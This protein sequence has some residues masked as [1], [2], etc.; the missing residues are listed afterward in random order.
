MHNSNWWVDPRGGGCRNLRT[1]I[2]KMGVIHNVARD[3]SSASLRKS[4]CCYCRLVTYL[5]RKT[6]RDVRI[7]FL[8]DFSGPRVTDTT[9]VAALAMFLLLLE[10]QFRPG[11]R[12]G[13]STYWPPIAPD[14]CLLILARPLLPQTIFDHSYL[15]LTFIFELGTDVILI[16]NSWKLPKIHPGKISNY[17]LKPPCWL[18]SRFVLVL[19][20]WFC[21]KSDFDFIYMLTKSSRRLPVFRPCRPAAGPSSK[22]LPQSRWWKTNG[23]NICLQF[24]QIASIR[25]KC[26]RHDNR[27]WR[28]VH[29][30]SWNGCTFITFII[31]DKNLHPRRRHLHH[32]HFYHLRHRQWH[33]HQSPSQRIFSN[34]LRI[35]KRT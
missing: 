30:T 22:K 16:E 10:F 34:H 24:W 23:D 25:K 31:I 18:E 1:A 28:T 21:T 12:W 13:R 7:L 27:S 29:L 20:S 11:G 17:I 15:L 4:D 8:S 19:E 33:L 2:L 3:V 9:H 32:H 35:P 6:A 26:H 14:P 5:L